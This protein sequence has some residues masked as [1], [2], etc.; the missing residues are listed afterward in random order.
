MLQIDH[1]PV[2]LGKDR[3][4]QTR[5]RMSQPE[6]PPDWVHP[7]G[8]IGQ[9]AESRGPQSPGKRGPHIRLIVEDAGPAFRLGYRH[10][11]AII[12]HRS[13]RLHPPQWRWP[14]RS[15]AIA[16]AALPPSD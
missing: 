13:D 8:E 12:E 4:E 15:G 2:R 10:H 14:R 16:L 9:R 5:L 1:Y 11:P 7:L 3:P 6:R